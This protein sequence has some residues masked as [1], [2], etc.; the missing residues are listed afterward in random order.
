MQITYIGMIT[1]NYK[2]YENEILSRV[3]E[4]RYEHI[5]RVTQT[6][7][8]LATLHKAD[9]EKAQIAAYFHDSCKLKNKDLI[10]ELCKKLA[11]DLDHEMIKAPAIIHGFLGAEM[12]KQYYGIDD[13][14]ILNAIRWHTTGR[15]GMSKLEKIV[16]LADYTEPKRDFPSA[17]KA[18]EI[19]LKELDKAMLY[20]LDASIKNLI[21]EN[22]YI[23]IYTINARN[24][25][26]EKNE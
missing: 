7:K 16:Y 9:V 21:E 18:R 8:N 19:S 1:V 26:L 25:F 24:Y 11:L 6:A 4:K 5:L 13:E 17:I 3:G 22:K 10:P 12:A 15:P 14:D 23:V 2:K 20:A